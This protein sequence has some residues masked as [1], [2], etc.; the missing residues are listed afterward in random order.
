MKVSII[1]PVRFRVDLTIVA[2][3][4]I[5]D[6]TKGIDYELIV[7]QDGEDTEMEEFLRTCR[8]NRVDKYIKIK[9]PVG[10]IKAINVGFEE[11]DTSS[12]YVMLLNS[13]IV[14]VPNW[15]DELIKGF[16]NDKVGIVLPTLPDSDL[17]QSIERNK[18]GIEYEYVE[19]MKGV[20]VLMKRELVSK[21]VE[22]KEK[23]GIKNK[24]ILD[25][26]FLLGGGDD[27]DLAKRTLQLGYKIC[28]ARKSFIYH[29]GSAAFRELFNN[30]VEYSKKY[31]SSM[32][33]KLRQ[34]WKDTK[35]SVLIAVPNVS[36]YIHHKLVIRLIEWSHYSDIRIAIRIYPNIVPHDNCRNKVVKEFLEEYFDYLCFIDDDI[37]PPQNCLRE[38]LIADKE[39][40]AP[41][42]FTM[43]EDDN[44][45]SVPMPVAHRYN[46]EGKYKI[47]YGTGIE[48]TD[49]ITGGMHLVKREVYEKLDRPYFFEYH[50]NG[51]TTY[52]EDFV[53]SRQCKKLGYKLYTH[54]DLICGHYKNINIKDI[55][56]IFIKYIK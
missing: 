6:Y 45:C 30:G 53:F 33:Y 49:I 47:Y 54:Y 20:C 17:P 39:I 43:K 35:P 9:D 1:M 18:K 12:D 3:N 7:V 56:D 23:Q 8:E 51:I 46:D 10:Y 42:C 50:A 28:I 21:L 36:G 29:Y 40:I 22:N 14:C 11:I 44:G 38:L 26:R 27:N 41:V 25:E 55:N 37:I 5:E 48:E 24:G 34:K 4:S 52:S 32:H 2:I 19:D 16:R 31:A 15:L 13:D